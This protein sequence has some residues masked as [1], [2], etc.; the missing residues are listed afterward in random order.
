MLVSG[1]VSLFTQQNSSGG[2]SPPPPATCTW[3]QAVAAN[4]EA[5]VARGLTHSLKLSLKSMVTLVVSPRTWSMNWMGV[6]LN[7][8]PPYNCCQFDGSFFCLEWPWK[9]SLESCCFPVVFFRPWRCFEDRHLQNLGTNPPL[10]ATASFW[11]TKTASN[12]FF[13]DRN[14][15]WTQSKSRNPERFV[16]ENGRVI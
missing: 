8:W 3:T 16:Q 13:L 11:L 6:P 1:R 15:V 5:A 14:R 9:S 10:I 4:G 2:Q 12:R 7:P